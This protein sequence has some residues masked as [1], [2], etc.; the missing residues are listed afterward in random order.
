MG[1]LDRET[2]GAEWLSSGEEQAH[3]AAATASSLAES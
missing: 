2:E 1:E 3:S